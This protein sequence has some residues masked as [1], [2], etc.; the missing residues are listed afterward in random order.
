MREERNEKRKR[1][2]PKTIFM[3]FKD[4]LFYQKEYK[5]KTYY[6]LYSKKCPNTRFLR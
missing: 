2:I 5:N 1:G 3:K 4:N 6:K